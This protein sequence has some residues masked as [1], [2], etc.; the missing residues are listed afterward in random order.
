MDATT[1]TAAATET[2][3]IVMISREVLE[4]Q[5]AET[6]NFKIGIE[7]KKKQESPSA[8]RKERSVR[9]R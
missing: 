2:E 8:T 6:R 1:G 3:E 9:G 4:S 5:K 7:K